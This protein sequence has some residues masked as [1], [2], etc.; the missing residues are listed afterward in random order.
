MGWSWEQVTA[1]ATILGVI[2]G[3]ISVYFLVLEVRRNAQ[4]LEG[5]TVQS[6]M[7]FEKD[8]FA[9][10]ADN[11]ALF[12]RGCADSEALSPEEKL[13]FTRIVGSLMS[14]YYSAYV[15]YVQE[16]IDDEVW[17]AYANAL[18]VNLAEPG[19]RTSW[20]AMEMRYPESFRHMIG[21]L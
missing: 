16:L 12:L 6:L 20:K 21:S 18:R 5:A 1:I 17:E 15:Q 2:G 7:N 3:L 10:V 14:L 9:L 4:A 19:F 13:R 8:V 11:A